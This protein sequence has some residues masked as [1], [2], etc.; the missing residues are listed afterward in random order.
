MSQDLSAAEKWPGANGPGGG[1]GT[2][3][4]ANP[5]TECSG[6]AT[7]TDVVIKMYFPWSWSS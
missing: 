1:P 5:Q 2:G 4:P 7:Y 3:W 6:K